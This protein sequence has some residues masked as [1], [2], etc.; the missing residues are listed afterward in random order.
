MHVK[1]Y[2]VG[3]QLFGANHVNLPFKN[4][5]KLLL[6]SFEPNRGIRDYYPDGGVER[7][8]SAKGPN[9]QEGVGKW[10]RVRRPEGV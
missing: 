9:N 5:G 3:C 1:H 4:Y 7:E 2:S 8:E 10:E 6:P